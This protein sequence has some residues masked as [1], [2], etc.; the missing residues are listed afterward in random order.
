M[1]SF[2]FLTDKHRPDAPVSF[3]TRSEDYSHCHR[4]SSS[5]RR[6]L[7]LPDTEHPKQREQIDGRGVGPGLTGQA[8]EKAS[9]TLR[10]EHKL[11]V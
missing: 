8:G 7:K 3:F 4:L 10:I 1:L 6:P 2:S 5:R 11:E 9:Y